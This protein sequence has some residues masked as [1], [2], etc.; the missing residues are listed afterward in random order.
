MTRTNKDSNTVY[1]YTFAKELGLSMSELR[2]LA[3]DI[4]WPDLR[5]RTWLAPVEQSKIRAWLSPRPNLG[6][7]E[8]AGETIS[9]CKVCFEP[10][11]YCTG[12]G[13]IGDPDG[14]A[15]MQELDYYDGE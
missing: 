2:F 11:D 10:S 3:R 7:A 5:P 6:I 15:L 1:A 4:G 12:H 9:F 8:Y 13:E 14:H